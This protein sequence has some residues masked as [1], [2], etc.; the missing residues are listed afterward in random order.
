VNGWVRSFRVDD[1]DCFQIQMLGFAGWRI[2]DVTYDP[3]Q[4]NW[5]VTAQLDFANL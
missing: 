2:I 4:R 3:H 1:P 5:V